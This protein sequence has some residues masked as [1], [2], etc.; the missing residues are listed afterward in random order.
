MK[1]DPT[2]PI[3]RHAPS[4]DG[5]QAVRESAR[6][7]IH[8]GHRAEAGWS[9]ANKTLPANAGASA[10]AEAQAELNAKTAMGPRADLP[11]AQA[12]QLQTVVERLGH[13]LAD[14][15]LGPQLHDS[16]R[17]HLYDAATQ[18]ADSSKFQSALAQ[19]GRTAE[20]L[21]QTS[22]GRIEKP[23]PVRIDKPELNTTPIDKALPKLNP[24]DLR[25]LPS[26]TQGAL[27]GGL[28]AA[29]T[30]AA[31]VGRDGH[32]SKADALE[33]GKQTALGTGT[34]ALTAAGERALTP[35]IDRQIGA[36][37]QKAASQTVSR[38]LPQVAAER[39]AALGATAR[40]LVSR[41]GGATVVGTVIATGTSAYENRKGLAK[42][43]AKAIGNVAADVT[44][45]AGSI[46][47]ATA[48]GAA[49]GSVVPIAG[50]AIGAVAGLAVGVG[51][52]YGAKIS[53]ARDALANTVSNWVTGVKSWF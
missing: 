19:L 47:T 14:G 20:E 32:L 13:A 45:A 4:N 2:A 37:V 11:C 46:A 21:D 34:G 30:A 10:Q 51:M 31:R 5:A 44:V 50:T 18:P 38:V 3:A 8:P 42:G 12:K 36:G 53:G 17:Q 27:F 28:G 16:L 29:A 1:I 6:P 7:I 40:A 26:A 43:D 33:I 23:T 39:S 22:P 15:H 41:V 48:V 25:H 49:I 35:M 9:L 52:T 24:L